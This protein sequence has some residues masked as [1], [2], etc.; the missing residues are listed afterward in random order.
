[1][2]LQN[3]LLLRTA[4]GELTE[5]AP[6]WMMRQA[7]RVLPEYR[8]VREQAGSF[9]TLAK[10]PELAAEVT[11]QPVD[12]FGVDAAIIFSD[13]LVIPEAMGLPYEMVES[14]GPVF[15]ETVRT[16]DDLKRLRVA[17]AESDLGYVLDAIKLTKKEL[18]G[19]VPLIGFAGA[20]FTIFCYMTEGKGSKTFSVAKKLLYTDPDFAHALLQQITDSTIGYLQAQIQ[21]GADLVQIFDS[22]AGILS[23][24]QYRTFS[25]PYIKQICDLITGTPDREV[26]ITVFAKGAFFA[27]QEIGQLSCDVV[28]L[29]WNMD[30]HES[31]Q[32]IP[33]RVLQGNLDPC[34]LYADFAQIRAEVKRMFDGFGHQHYIA[35]LGHGIYPDTDRDKARCFVDAVK[36]LGAV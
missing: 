29:D 34:V 3:D 35:N 24:E 8:A 6:V 21:A 17:D 16:M 7:G 2:T 22:W 27:R 4:R 23:P 12:A 9:I 13:I 25:L 14:R 10:T 15:P 5:R 26:P 11:I 32:L 28:G 20:P 31:R 33:D 19:R 1:M 18:N 36:E 30:P